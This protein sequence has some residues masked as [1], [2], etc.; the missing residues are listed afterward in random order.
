MNLFYNPPLVIKKL[1]NNYYWTTSNNKILLTFDDGPTVEATELILKTLNEFDIKALFFCVGQN[2]ER[3]SILAKEILTQGHSIGNHNY[4]HK[5]LLKLSRE[6][7]VIE[8]KKC[9]DVICNQLGIKPVYYRPPFGKY[10]LSTKKMLNQLKLKNIMWSLLPY[11]FKNDIEL[12]KSAVDKN[13]RSDS[14]IVLHDNIKSRDI[15]VDSIRYIA[16]Q[17]IRKGYL[18]GEP[19]ECLK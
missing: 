7:Q 14:I 17:V 3:N 15:I 19:A 1:F 9:N 10:R 2:I 11:D 18:F 16:E 12:V 4:S 5:S 6:N 8:I 13:L